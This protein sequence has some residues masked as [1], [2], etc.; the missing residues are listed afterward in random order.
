VCRTMAQ[1]QSFSTRTDGMERYTCQKCSR[2]FVASSTA[3]KINCPNCNFDNVLRPGAV[4]SSGPTSSGLPAVPQYSLEEASNVAKALVYENPDSNGWSPV[5]VTYDGVEGCWSKPIATNINS[6]KIFCNKAV[7]IMDAP[8]DIV[9]SV[10]WNPRAEL[11]WNST[12][13]QKVTLLE[14]L[15]SIQVLHHEL[16]KNAICN[17]QNDITFRR[18]YDKNPDGSIWV[19]AVSVSGSGIPAANPA[20]ARGT[21]VFGGVLIKAIANNKTQ[22]TLIWC[23]DYNKQL[24]VRYVD[25]EPKRTALRLCRIKKMI[26]EAAA[27]AKRTA[28]YN[29]QK[30]AAGAQ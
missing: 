3:S 6:D 9:L 21:V 8:P 7:S 25:E 15:S 5:N 10:Y 4:T 24:K 17:F 23:F 29:K 20:F 30:A 14:D 2:H 19:Y 12:T 27:V 13:L 26:D 11:E 28:E 1:Q 18:A 16:K 22:V